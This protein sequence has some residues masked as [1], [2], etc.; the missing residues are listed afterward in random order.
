[1]RTWRPRRLACRRDCLP[2][3]QVTISN[4]RRRWDEAH[5]QWR[6]PGFVALSLAGGAYRE[7]SRDG[8]GET[9]WKTF[10][11]ILSSRT[12]HTSGKLVCQKN[13]T[14]DPVEVGSLGAVGVVLEAEEIAKLV[15]E[16]RLARAGLRRHKW[17]HERASF[18]NPSQKA[19]GFQ[20]AWMCPTS[21]LDSCHTSS[22]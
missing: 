8:G 3:R 15:E 16:F 18:A 20:T 6:S 10:E 22:L 14:A 21:K 11:L 19:S 9:D 13:V 12:R 17:L 7:P 1:M 5:R 2:K 4:W